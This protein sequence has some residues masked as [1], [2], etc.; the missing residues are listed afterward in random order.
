MEEAFLAEEGIACVK[1]PGTGEHGG[2]N[3]KLREGHVGQ[4]TQAGVCAERPRA[5]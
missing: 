3:E 5:L 4:R 2:D 1:T